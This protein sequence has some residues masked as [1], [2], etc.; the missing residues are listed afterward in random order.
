MR[1]AHRLNT[2]CIVL[3]DL[4][5]ST[6]FYIYIAAGHAR[7]SDHAHVPSGNIHIKSYYTHTSTYT[8]T[9]AG[10]D[11]LTAYLMPFCVI[12]PGDKSGGDHARIGNT[13]PI[14]QQRLQKISVPLP[15]RPSWELL[16]GYLFLELNFEITAT[17][18]PDEVRQVLVC[19]VTKPT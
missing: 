11:I 6:F 18:A 3:P 16:S 2:G 9:H 13:V 7:L 17:P 10:G 12:S 4:V 15:Q 5:T 14:Y 8:H 19:G 1:L